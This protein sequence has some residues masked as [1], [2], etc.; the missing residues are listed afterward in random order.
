VKRGE[1]WWYEHPEAGRRPFLILTRLEAIPV[2]N[3][4]IAIP[5]TRTIRAIP[6]EV[7]LDESDGMAVPCV[8]AVDQVT[9]IRPSLCTSRITV[10]G[11]E[12]LTA[13]CQ[14]LRVATAC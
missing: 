2:L 3:Q 4:V 10:L 6:T 5:A 7:A 11:A 1:V 14:A 8:L 9:L 12:K 13:V